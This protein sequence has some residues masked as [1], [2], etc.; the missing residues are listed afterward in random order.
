MR[1]C[2][3]CR[4]CCC[5]LQFSCSSIEYK[6]KRIHFFGQFHWAHFIYLNI[7][8]IIFRLQYFS[9]EQWVKHNYF[10]QMSFKNDFMHNFFKFF[11]RLLLFEEISNN[12]KLYHLIDNSWDFKMHESLLKLNWHYYRI[13][14]GGF[15]CILKTMMWFDEKYMKFIIKMKKCQNRVHSFQFKAL[16]ATQSAWMNRCAPGVCHTVPQIKQ[17]IADEFKENIPFFLMCC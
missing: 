1:I 9:T 3:E 16:K 7:R 12:D 11:I 5:P 17:I 10:E 6:E 2:K 8:N 15:E 13:S 14:A 4:E